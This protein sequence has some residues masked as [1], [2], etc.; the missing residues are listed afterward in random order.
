MFSPLFKAHLGHFCPKKGNLCSNTATDIVNIHIYSILSTND[1]CRA[2]E[3]LRG[4]NSSIF[5]E[6][7]FSTLG[8]L[9]HD[10]WSL[11]MHG[12]WP[13]MAKTKNFCV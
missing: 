6:L 7:H 12:T 11:K 2:L 10:T 1:I 9:R 5:E 13:E 4:L 3:W 8:S